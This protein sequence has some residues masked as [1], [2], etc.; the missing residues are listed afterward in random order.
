MGE[1]NTDFSEHRIRS[2]DG[3]GLYVRDYGSA[4]NSAT[5]VLCLP[6][7]TR[8]SN[9]FHALAL[10]LCGQRRVLSLDYRGRGRSD[11][12]HDWRHYIPVTYVNDVRHVLAALGVQRAF[13]VGTSLGGIIA[14]AMAAA[15]PTSLAGALLNDVGPE[16]SAAGLT[17]IIK[18]MQAEMPLRDWDAAVAR[19]KTFFPDRLA[20][21]EEDWLQMARGTYRRR[22]DGAIVYD[23]DEAILKPILSTVS[24][25][26]D[27]WP[28]FLALGKVPLVAVR[29][30]LSDILSE[31]TFHRM[32][33]VMPRL[34]QVTVAGVGHAPTLNETEVLEV[35]DGKLAVADRTGH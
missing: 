24:H 7:L 9:D 33:K 5:V 32:A 27:L 14:M 17:K 22:N 16:I 1:T 29:G 4:A 25:K 31:P 11:Y 35:L 10:H 30:G 18:Y 12:D 15:M 8:N 2:Q 3:L 23:W 19:L 34:T 21:D 28:L 26:I 6:G 13:V 20:Q